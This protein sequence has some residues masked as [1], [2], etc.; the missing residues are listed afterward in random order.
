MIKNTIIGKIAILE[1]KLFYKEVHKGEE[2]SKE[3]RIKW[4]NGNY[5][6]DCPEAI[7]WELFERTLDALME[8]NS[9]KVPIL[10]EETKLR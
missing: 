5:N 6:F 10:D 3:D 8:G 1:Q 4:I 7:D 9:Y 2:M